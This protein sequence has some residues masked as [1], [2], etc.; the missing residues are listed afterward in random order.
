MAN[1]AIYGGAFN[2]PHLAHVAGVDTALATPK[3]DSVWL[4]PCHEHAFAKA[5][6]AFSTRVTMCRAMIA[7]FDSNRV[8]ITEIE[9][10]LPGPNRTIDTMA[11]LES[12]HPEHRFRLIVGTDIFL[13]QEQW[14]DF[15][16]LQQRYPFVVLGRPGFEA[17]PGVTC[18]P[19]LPDVSS[20]EIRRRVREGLSVATLV[21]D[22]VAAIIE[23]KELYR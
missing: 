11:A 20:T 5:M 6:V 1:V 9:A 22:A 19:P 7:A 10:T 2:P 18:S 21:P 23:N 13:E 15:D 3:V 14:K 16:V 12:L 17:P 8:G 4:M